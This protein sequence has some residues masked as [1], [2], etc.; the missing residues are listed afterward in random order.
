[1]Y[2]Q[3]PVSIS[4]PTSGNKATILTHDYI[5][6]G[7]L[8]LDSSILQGHNAGDF[9]MVEVDYRDGFTEF[10]G[11]IQMDSEKTIGII[12]G[13]SGIVSF[14]LAARSSVY[15][16]FGV[17]FDD[18]SVF[19]STKEMGSLGS[20][21]TLGVSEVGAYYIDYSEGIVY[22]IVGVGQELK[23]GVNISYS[24]RDLSFESNNLYSVDYKSGVLYTSKIQKQSTTKNIRYKASQHT[25]SY[26]LSKEIDLYK[27]DVSRN[28]VSIRTEG[29]SRINNLVKVVWAK[30]QVKPRLNELKRYFSPIVNTFGIRF[31]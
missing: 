28:V 3:R 27:Y 26:D 19:D 23:S 29:M 12:A 1:V 22:V 14:A 4:D 2:G 13:S 10:L 31:Q 30:A 17:S 20:L 11:L 25:V 9:T 18:S 8:S 21:E 16:E 6:K 15:K 5:V 7:T 24:Y